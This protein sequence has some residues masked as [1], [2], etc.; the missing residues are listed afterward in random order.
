MEVLLVMRRLLL[1]LLLSVPALAQSYPTTTNLKLQLPPRLT[2][3]GW[4]L[5]VNSNSVIIDALF[6]NAPCGGDGVH[7]IGL[8][9]SPVYKFVCVSISS[10]SGSIGGSLN[11][12]NAIPRV[13]APNVLGDG[14]LHDDGAG[15]ISL[16][17]CMIVFGGAGD[18]T[19]CVAGTPIGGK[20]SILD[21]TSDGS[22]W[23]Q[24]WT[25]TNSAPL[26]F[27]SMIPDSTGDFIFGLRAP[28]GSLIAGL[29]FNND[30]TIGITGAFKNVPVSGL[31]SW[32]Q[33][34][35]GGLS[36][37]A[38]QTVPA[39]V[40]PYIYEMPSTGGNGALRMDFDEANGKYKLSAVADPPITPAIVTVINCGTVVACADATQHSPIVAYGSVPLT[41]ASPSTASVT[42]LTFSSSTSYRCT[43]T[44]EGTT[45]AIAAGGVAINRTSGT[46][47]TLTG[48]N[49]VTTI[50]DFVC[51]GN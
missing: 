25:A 3:P 13:I 18:M 20:G 28:A 8:E 23:N 42:T 16:N 2:G 39:V 26:N 7:A 14:S 33:Q 30:G 48:P 45:A 35:N 27:M 47:M 44:P 11:N 12:V 22:V 10:G 32:A 49:T 40:S 34:M 29:T 21:V 31:G 41:S 19:I 5:A 9:T 1:L 15:N 38:T 51:W 17:G 24:T 50:I 46:T 6:P 37:Y 4:G 43:A 36:G